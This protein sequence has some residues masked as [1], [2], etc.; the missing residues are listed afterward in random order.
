MLTIGYTQKEYESMMEC[1]KL[2]AIHLTNNKIW[3]GLICEREST[4]VIF[5]PL[6]LEY[7]LGNDKKYHISFDYV[8]VASKDEIYILNNNNIL[9]CT[10]LNPLIKSHYTKYYK[11]DDVDKI[12]DSLD[13]V[14][15]SIE[16]DNT[17]T[18][19]II[20]ISKKLH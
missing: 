4:S 2:M 3:V 8:S 7:Y 15:D 14:Y 11:I 16:N 17:E 1:S 19:N 18:N 13:S 9:F 10:T 6:Q 5:N 20:K 12:D